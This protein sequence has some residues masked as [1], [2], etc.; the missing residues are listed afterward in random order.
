M[1]GPSLR[2]MA[3]VTPHPQAFPEEP[4]AQHG[5]QWKAPESRSRTT[6]PPT[7]E[8]GAGATEKAV[9]GDGTWSSERR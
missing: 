3:W 6:L 4:G 5:P 2:A 9:A 1:V 8:R 7:E